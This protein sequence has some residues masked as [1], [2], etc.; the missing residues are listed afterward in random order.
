MRLERVRCVLDQISCF[1]TRQTNKI[2]VMLEF[3]LS[4]D[5]QFCTS[6]E[7]RN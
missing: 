5:I 2:V 7:F 1:L 4:N 3:E 6:M